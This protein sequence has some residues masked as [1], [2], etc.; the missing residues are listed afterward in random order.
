M[1]FISEVESLLLRNKNGWLT[2]KTTLDAIQK[3][4]VVYDEI[5]QKELEIMAKEFYADKRILDSTI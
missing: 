2:D 4:I 1:S 5:E 3:L